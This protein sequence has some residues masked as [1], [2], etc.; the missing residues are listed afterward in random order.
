MGFSELIY[1][2][3]LSAELSLLPTVVLATLN[4]NVCPDSEIKV[5][6]YELPMRLPHG[7]LTWVHMW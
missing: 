7:Q 1:S 3:A 5:V 2:V 6:R 4:S